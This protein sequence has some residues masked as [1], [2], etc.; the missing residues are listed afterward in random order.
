ML[1]R[2]LAS[3]SRTQPSQLFNW[4]CKFELMELD[5]FLMFRHAEKLITFLR[6]VKVVTVW[7]HELNSVNR[8]GVPIHTLFT[9]I[10]EK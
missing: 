5:Q 7:P 9:L 10:G 3:T 4:E 6:V 2:E 1:H 8:E